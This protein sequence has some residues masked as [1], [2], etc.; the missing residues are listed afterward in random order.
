M[1][2]VEQMKKT[3]PCVTC[4]ITFGQ[5]V[6]EL[7]FDVGVPNLNLGIQIILS[8]NLSKATL[9]ILDTCLIVGLRSF[10]IF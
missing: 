10:I 1:A 5:I 7:M 9:W 4:E 3:I 8:N 6:C 2:D